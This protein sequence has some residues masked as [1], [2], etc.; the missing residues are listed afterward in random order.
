MPMKSISSAPL[1]FFYRSLCKMVYSIFSLPCSNIAL[2]KAPPR[3]PM[4]PVS[5]LPGGGGLGG[6]PGVV[7]S[8]LTKHSGVQLLAARVSA[9]FLPFSKIVSMFNPLSLLPSLIGQLGEELLFFLAEV[10]SNG[11]STQK[12][13]HLRSLTPSGDPSPRRLCPKSDLVLLQFTHWRR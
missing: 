5:L 3:L 12:D 10:V 1:R 7:H 9:S 2:P 11:F 4:T 6:V 8:K 13:P